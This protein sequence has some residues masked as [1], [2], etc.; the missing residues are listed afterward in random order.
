VICK[1]VFFI[2]NGKNGKK[3]IVEMIGASGD[4]LMKSCKALR[5]AEMNI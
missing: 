3:F 2:E 4:F 5:M 1:I